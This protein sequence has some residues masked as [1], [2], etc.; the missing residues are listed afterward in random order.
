MPMESLRPYE[1][2]IMEEDEVTRA[3]G[4]G[5]KAFPNLQAPL[6]LLLH[7]LFRGNRG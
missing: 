7:K 6:L 1:V 3:V 5:V 4:V 2:E